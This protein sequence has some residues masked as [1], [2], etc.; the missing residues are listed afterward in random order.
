MVVGSDSGDGN[1]INHRWVT[2]SILLSQ[3][4]C[5][6]TLGDRH[7]LPQRFFADCP[8]V[9]VKDSPAPIYRQAFPEVYVS[10]PGP[11]LAP[12]CGRGEMGSQA[13]WRRVSG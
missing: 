5:F 10:F 8:D 3:C 4:S 11:Q 7:R 6:C 1:G 13:D 9:T 2:L 12:F